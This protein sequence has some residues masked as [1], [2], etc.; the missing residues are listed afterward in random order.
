MYE[1]L[2][3]QCSVKVKATMKNI[4]VYN[5]TILEE[6]LVQSGGTSN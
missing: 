2:S 4:S 6:Y 1:P 5:Y 3:L